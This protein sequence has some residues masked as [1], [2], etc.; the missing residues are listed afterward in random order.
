MFKLAGSR[1]WIAGATGMV[2]RALTRRLASEQCELV[3][4]PARIDLRDQHA[5]FAWIASARPD[6]IFLAAARVGG[7]LANRDRPA[8]FLYDNLVIQANVI[9]GA[10]RAKVSRLVAIGSSASYPAEAAQPISESALLTGPLDPAH[11]GYSIAK[12]AGIKLC[13]TYRRQYGCHFIATQPTNLYGPHDNFDAEGSHVLAG[14][15]RKAHEAKLASAGSFELWG[16][17]KPLREFL[18]VDDF[19]NALVFLAQRY[20]GEEPVNVGSGEEVSIADLAR[21]VADVVGFSGGLTLDAT[22]PDGVQRKALDSSRLSALGWRP[23]TLLTRG[24]KE[25]YRWYCNE[26][27]GRGPNRPGG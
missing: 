21:L 19:A 10:R 13:Q 20:D 14:L 26:G 7:I 12:I 9:E 3:A 5:A 11:E 16:S 23:A 15:M 22:R 24:L 1:V 25:T 17:G 6:F 18:Y 8:E 4:P 27:P 2:G